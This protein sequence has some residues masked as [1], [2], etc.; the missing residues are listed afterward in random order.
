MDGTQREVIGVLPP[1][2]VL[3]RQEAAI[4]LPLQVDRAAP[5]LGA[6]KIELSKLLAQ[7]WPGDDGN[8]GEKTRGKIW[9]GSCLV[10]IGGGT[11]PRRN[12]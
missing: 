4:Y 11:P 5:G 3:P 7:P 1:E 6:V 10:M 8:L 9:I 2:F 12:T